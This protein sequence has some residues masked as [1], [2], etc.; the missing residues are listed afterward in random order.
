MKD[1]YYDAF[2]ELFEKMKSLSTKNEID[3]LS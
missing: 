3:L 1:C 2:V